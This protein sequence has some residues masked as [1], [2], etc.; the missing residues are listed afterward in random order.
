MLLCEE[1]TKCFCQTLLEQAVFFFCVFLFPGIPIFSRIEPGWFVLLFMRL[2]IITRPD[3]GM[4][5]G[6]AVPKKPTLP[7]KLGPQDINLL[8]DQ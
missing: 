6:K 8:H 5:H 1:I 7:R 4:Q 3:M 2:P